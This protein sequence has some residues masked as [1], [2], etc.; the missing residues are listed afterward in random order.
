VGGVV[1]SRNT[2]VTEIYDPASDSWTTGPALGAARDHFVL[3]E[4]DGRLFAIGGR[5]VTAARNIDTVEILEPGASAWTFG[6]AMPQPRSGIAGSVVN[7]VVYTFGGEEPGQTDAEVFAYTTATD[8]WSD[9]MPPMPTPRHGLA[10][11]AV[12]GQI[13]VIGGGTSPGGGSDSSF[14]EIL[15][16]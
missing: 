6:A 5:L 1:G 13:H 12:N 4:S 16:P 15:T 9:G 2:P 3:A 8:T 14:H 11:I 10:A 7:G